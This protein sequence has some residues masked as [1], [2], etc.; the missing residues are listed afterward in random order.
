M[1]D[2][3]NKNFSRM[4]STSFKE[5]TFNANSSSGIL[6]NVKQSASNFSSGVPSLFAETESLNTSV[7]TTA[8]VG[9]TQNALLIQLIRHSVPSGSEDKRKHIVLLSSYL[10]RILNSRIYTVNSV[11]LDEYS[12]TEMIK[13]KLVQSR[14]TTEEEG[15]KKAVLFGYLLKKLQICSKSSTDLYA[16][17]LRFLLALM[18]SI[19]K[20][21]NADDMG[22]AS[23]GGSLLLLAGINSVSSSSSALFQKPLSNAPSGDFVV[24]E[25]ERK[26]SSSGNNN[27][28]GHVRKDLNQ[29]IVREFVYSC[30]LLDVSSSSANVIK[31]QNSQPILARKKDGSYEVNYANTSLSLSIINLLK[32]M[33]RLPNEYLEFKRLLETDNSGSLVRKCL[34]DA[35]KSEDMEYLRFID[36]LSQMVSSDQ[37][38]SMIRVL[39]LTRQ[40]LKRILCVKK[41]LT[42]AASKD[43]NGI[44]LLNRIYSCKSDE[45]SDVLPRLWEMCV[46]PFYEFLKAWMER[47]SLE[48]PYDEFII[49]KSTGVNINMW[50][51][52]FLKKIDVNFSLT[53]ELLRRIYV[54]GK[55]L[56]YLKYVDK[57]PQYTL[58]MGDKI[59]V[60]LI[61]SKYH[62]VNKCMIDYLGR[63]N[64]VLHLKAMKDYYLMGKGDFY[65]NIL[66]EFDSLFTTSSQSGW[67][68]GVAVYRH[69][70]VNALD[71]CVDKSVAKFDDVGVKQRLDV[72]LLGNDAD[73][74]WSNLMIDYKTTSSES[75]SNNK[76]DDLI[77][78]FLNDTTVE[79][80]EKVF[81]LLFRIRRLS[82]NAG[83]L[84]R[85]LSIQQKMNNTTNTK[86]KLGWRRTGYVLFEFQ[87]C[88]LNAI[89]SHFQLFFDSC[90]DSL[91]S[92]F[93]REEEDTQG[94]R[95]DFDSIVDF[96]F[97]S[98]INQ[99]G[100]LVSPSGSAKG[101]TPKEVTLSFYVLLD[102]IEKYLNTLKISLKKGG[103]VRGGSVSSLLSPTRPNWDS[104]VESDME[105]LKALNDL[106]SL[107]DG[108]YK[109]RS[110]S[111][112]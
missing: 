81:V 102:T 14:N 48:D 57:A 53:P 44:E 4:L 80:Y 45:D 98:Y 63:S 5:N 10:N 40:Q 51:T 106:N 78:V 93:N 109:V 64:L 103:I 69:L 99:I 76:E 100:H 54:I 72:R 79:I 20:G 11:A 70:L 77:K 66:K 29:R 18:D 68:G 95:H 39:H 58:P 73:S 65:L 111:F 85:A 108:P 74:P 105:W 88:L 15:T 31:D 90:F 86:V 28:L 26:N 17:V 75:S 30:Q 84:Q 9:Y 97:N 52:Y 107:Y 104:S 23:A 59:T 92:F 101:T 7:R 82:C 19:G 110:T 38:I 60:E 87:T 8:T 33:I 12:V 35:A 42:I 43:L 27:V 67:D 49:S 83:E 71:D 2:G 6:P 91:I 62:H 21:S 61:N 32:E 46:K 25:K 96:Y 37:H 1:A 55:T 24:D 112:S 50:D 47:G 56:N 34:F 22:G 13:K 89:F 36:S 94:H 16:N 3:D 41:V